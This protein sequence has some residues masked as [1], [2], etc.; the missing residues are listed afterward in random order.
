MMTRLVVHHCGIALGAWLLC[1][2]AT[3]ARADGDDYFIPMLN[4]DGTAVFEGGYTGSVKDDKGRR[5]PDATIKIVVTVETAEG[6]YPLTLNT[7]SDVLG[8][9]RSRDPKVVFADFIADDIAPGSIELIVMKDGYDV[10]RRITRGRVNKTGPF[11][12]DFIL[13]EKPRESG[14]IPSR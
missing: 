9:Y 14:A 2:Q 1:L 4:P 12:I 6:P 7:Y 3:P 11:E 13:R 8:R 10:V 5:V